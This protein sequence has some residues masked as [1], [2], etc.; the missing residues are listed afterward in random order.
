MC[1][2]GTDVYVT[3]AVTI[4]THRVAKMWKNGV[5]TD[6]TDGTNDADVTDIFVS[7]TDVYI[8]GSEINGGY[9][10]AKFWKNGVATSLSNGS[11]NAGTSGLFIQP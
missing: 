7:G 10:V 8:S 5:A 2:S 9:S 3:G 6:L 4:G 1:V 11:G